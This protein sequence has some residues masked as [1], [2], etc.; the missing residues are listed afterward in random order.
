ML[1]TPDFIQMSSVFPPTFSRI[2]SRKPHCI[3][4]WDVLNYSS[5][6]FNTY[7]LFPLASILA[8]CLSLEICPFHLSCQIH[9]HTV[10]IFFYYPVNACRICIN[11]PYSIPRI[12]HLYY[13]SCFC[14]QQRFIIFIDLFSTNQLL[15]LLILP[16]VFLFPV[17]LNSAL[18]F[19]IFL[20]LPHILGEVFIFCL[21]S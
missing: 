19:I 20:F 8:V 4:Y 7:F 15:I 6:S 14:D 12:Y 16:V 9:W 21:A 3:Q 13:L 5:N 11:H 1:L 10:V 18:T 17:S 2:Q